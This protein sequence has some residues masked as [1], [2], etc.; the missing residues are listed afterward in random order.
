MK[1]KVRSYLWLAWISLVMLFAMSCKPAGSKAALSPPKKA[2]ELGETVPDEAWK[3]CQERVR[4]DLKY[5]PQRAEFTLKSSSLWSVETGEF[6][7]ESYEPL[8]WR[9][10]AELLASN[11]FGTLVRNDLRCYIGYD[12]SIPA[13]Q[14]KLRETVLFEIV[15]PGQRAMLWE[16]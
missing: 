16:K 14:G 8:L 12:K 2:G 7:T 9:F 10:D 4:H 13:E 1:A 15:E 5:D 11:A 3:K 6:A